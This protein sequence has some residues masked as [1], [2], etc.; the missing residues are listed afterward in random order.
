[1]KQSE[2]MWPIQFLNEIEK[3]KTIKRYNRTLDG[4]QENPAEHSWNAA[5][6]AMV[7]APYAPEGTSIDRVIKM[8]IVH[9]L[10]EVYHGD[11]CVYDEDYASKS[12][13]EVYS[14]DALLTHLSAPM[15]DMIK[16]LWL[17]FD[18][19]QSPDA[20][21]AIAID[22]LQPLSNHLITGDPNQG[23]IDVEKVL[24]KKRF[25]RSACPKLWPLVEQLIAD[26]KKKGL[27]I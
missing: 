22:G 21:F 25:I 13:E 26:S 24:E 20:L 15:R 16:A 27:Y 23:Q 8:L 18:E 10:A 4:R 14:L 17:E 19:H 12:A 11:V 5:M 3:L 9:D 2:P 1:M 7:L 6:M